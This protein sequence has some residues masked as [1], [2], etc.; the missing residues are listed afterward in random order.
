MVA[1]RPRKRPDRR[2][3]Q[4]AVRQPPR[5][6]GPEHLLRQRLGD[7]LAQRPRR[8]ARRREHPHR[9]RQRPLERHHQLRRQRDRAELPRA[10]ACASPSRPT[11]Q[12]HLNTSDTD[13]GS[14]APALLGRRP[15]R[16]G[17][18]GRDHA[19]AR[20][21]ALGRSPALRR[22]RAPA[23]PRRRSPAPADTR[24]RRAVHRAPARVVDRAH[25]RTTAFLADESG[26][27]AYV[28]RSGLLYRAWENSNRRHQPVMAGGLLYVYDLSGGGINVYRPG[29]PRPIAKLAGHAR[30]LEQPDRGRRAHDRAR[31]QRQ[32]PRNSAA[33]WRS[34]RP[35]SASA[36][37]PGR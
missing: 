10:A 16:A 21:L 34:S 32:R 25:G 2:D 6:A 20:A 23:P 24:R 14:S 3:L 35:D 17:G 18:Q 15:H 5:T 27:A 8:R 19:R 30:A 33:D 28:L 11:D 22:P 4:H 13:L 7:P 31:G 1:D 12:E 37:R 29:S 9:H 36:G 26:T